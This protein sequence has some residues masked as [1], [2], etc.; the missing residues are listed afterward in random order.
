VSN[1]FS[2]PTRIFA[3]AALACAGAVSAGLVTQHVYDMQPCPWCILQRLIFVLI[4][5]IAVLGMLW[6]SRAGIL[7]SAFAMDL[8][9]AAGVAAA[10][11]QHFVAAS[12]SSCN[13]TLADK[14]IAG[15][16]LDG[17][18]PEIFAPRAS[19]SD[20]AVTLF[21]VPYEFWS[22]AIF[23]ML[24]ALAVLVILSQIRRLR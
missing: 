7:S 16:G 10:L 2:N 1:L 4:G 22:L 13:L 6:R 12:S 18:A 8:L 19:C 15:S 5:L 20:A 23:S 21:G 11:W 9:A 14:I 3:L 17:M 24:G